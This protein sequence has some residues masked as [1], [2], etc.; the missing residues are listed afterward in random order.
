MA[1]EWRDHPSYPLSVST[2]GRVRSHKTGRVLRGFLGGGGS[3]GPST[4]SRW[5]PNTYRKVSVGD[6]YGVK[7][8]R[9]H[10]L[11][12]ET[13]V[14]PCPEGHDADHINGDRED[15]RLANL[16]WL[17]AVENRGRHSRKAAC[18]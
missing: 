2:E 18:E 12:L 6:G 4:G 15:N 14:G 8:P 17:D 13:F 9:V 10:R 5:R 7:H 16:R 3:S 11:V 1:E